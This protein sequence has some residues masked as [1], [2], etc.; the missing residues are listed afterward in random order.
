VLLAVGGSDNLM[1][2]ITITKQL[3]DAAAR[4]AEHAVNPEIIS[5]Y[6]QPTDNQYLHKRRNLKI[7]DLLGVITRATVL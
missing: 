1:R 4:D 6:T 7:K 2:K 3:E 5:G